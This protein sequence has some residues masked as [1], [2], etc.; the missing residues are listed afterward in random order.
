MNI[1]AA[2]CAWPWSDIILEKGA[3]RELLCQAHLNVFLY[4]VMLE[5]G[6][7]WTFFSKETWLFLGLLGTS[8]AS[9]CCLNVR[10]SIW[11]INFAQLR[12]KCCFHIPSPGI[13]EPLLSTK[14][15]HL[16]QRIKYNFIP[17][18]VLTVGRIWA[19]GLGYEQ[20]SKSQCRPSSD[21]IKSKSAAP[22][23]I[24]KV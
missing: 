14:N 4:R 19:L 6:H 11:L 7:D 13:R 22:K 24:A 21:V 15:L 10:V 1:R 17:H 18:V 23:T 9:T 8:L 5:I 16:Y 2:H 12:S 3:Y 20:K